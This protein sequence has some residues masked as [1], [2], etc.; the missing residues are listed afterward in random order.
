M[1]E[2]AALERF[3]QSVKKIGGQKAFATAHD[4]SAQYVCDVLHGRRGLSDTICKAI[5]L[6]RETVYREIMR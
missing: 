4:M 1:T 2:T 3:R 5:G 6:I